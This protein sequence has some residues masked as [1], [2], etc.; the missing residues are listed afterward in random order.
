VG[1]RKERAELRAGFEAAAAGRGLLL[2]V[3]GEPGIGKTTLVEDFLAELA[4]AGQVFSLARGRCSERLAGA[5]AYLP[6]LEALDTL[7]RGDG[8]SWVARVMK[9]VAPTW[10]VQVA[11]HVAGDDSF[12]RV[13]A[14]ARVASQE[15]MKRE[16]I[17]FLEEV[18]GL[19]PLI[20]FIDD[21]HWADPSTVDLLA[22]VGSRC[23]N[24]RVL[25]VLT[26]RPS[27]LMLSKH[28]LLS[29]KL[30]L[31]GRG[32]CREVAVTFLERPDIDLYLGLAF[33]GHRFPGT[34]AA[35]L[36]GKTEGNPLFLVDLLH[37]LK[38]LRVL[39]EEQGRWVLAQ[40]LAEFEG[41]LP[42]SVRSMI[43][44]KIDQLGEADRR[45]LA[46]GS[47]QGN[48]F[49][50]AVVAEA[51]GLGAADAEE[52]L[53]VLERAHDLVRCAGEREF[54][55]GVLTLRYRF[56]HVLYQN[57][58]Y[59]ALAPARKSS[60][61]AAVARAL[62]GHL[63][64]Q[65]D[66]VAADLA[67]LFEAA[68]D[69]AQAADHF[70]T[71]S[72]NA[73]RVHANQEAVALARRA[74]ATAEKLRG[75]ERSPRVLAAALHLGPLHQ[76]HA[77]FEEALADYELAERAA[78]E[79]G[80]L[81]AHVNA[82]SG[83][84]LV[85]TCLRRRPE[86]H[87]RGMRALELARAAGSGVGEACAEM[88]LGFERVQDGD[89]LLAEQ[90]YEKAIPVLKEQGPPIH[91]V[92][93]VGL[94]GAIHRFRL[95]ND[96]AE[97]AMCWALERAREIGAGFHIVENLLNLGLVHGN[98][99]RLSEALAALEEGMR[100]AALNDE[101]FWLPRIPNTIGW[102]HREL[103]D[104]ENA[105]RLDREGAQLARE[106]GQAEAEA[107]SRVNLGHDYLALSEPERAFE[108]LQEAQRILDQDD[109]MRWR[110]RI[111]LQAELAS[112]WITR[113]DLQAASCHAG[114][115]LHLAESSLSRKHVAWGHKLLGDIAALEERMEEAQSRYQR[116]LGIL[117]GHPCPVIEW[118]ILVAAAG[119]ARRLGDE[120]GSTTSLGRAR[121][122]L[123][124]LADS[125]HDDKLRRRFLASRAVRD[126][127]P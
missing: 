87:E 13:L 56:V 18:A 36:H 122:V 34:F 49:D 81:E 92:A 60:W 79:C 22:Y 112:Y 101:R 61:S 97:R 90:Y 91:A 29:V 99:G 41:A 25:L 26:Y 117:A 58:L 10:Y 95:E 116:A 88:A 42:E 30:E 52:R 38:D 107:N 111:R 94:R 20:F 32:T 127:A 51:L 67:L 106:M 72:R 104:V 16:F 24:L 6:V 47:V 119:V 21:V 76:T 7:L 39:V 57:A 11:P 85:L 44:K 126:L 65:T 2:G 82:V 83:Q 80:N 55:D 19:Q 33:P 89:L 121:A 43:R 27:D 66:A 98:R 1:R 59:A 86:A 17:A 45:L 70:L 71:A 37:Y 15:R 14:E 103:Q 62:A 96:G 68:R 100:L 73:A 110:Y 102:V 69:F 120:A 125:L 114:T 40:G 118:K 84:S 93:A 78:R 5:E 9:L 109:W 28:P 64:G 31:Q 48:E 74:V 115:S 35:L 54:P 75:P 105:L 77:Q 123:Q 23:A 63:A 124:A 50:A 46:A 8:G 3:A 12:A 4:A 113:E 53:G 108:Q